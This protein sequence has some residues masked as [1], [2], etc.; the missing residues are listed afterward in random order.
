MNFARVLYND[1]LVWKK[2]LLSGLLD[3]VLIA[4]YWYVFQSW[5]WSSE[6]VWMWGWISVWSSQ[7]YTDVATARCRRVQQE[8][9]VG[10]F[11]PR[12]HGGFLP[13]Q[14]RFLFQTSLRWLIGGWRGA[15]GRRVIG[16][17]FGRHEFLHGKVWN[18]VKERPTSAS[19]WKAD[20]NIVIADLRRRKKKQEKKTPLN[21]R[22]REKRVNK[23][24][25]K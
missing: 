18:S 15:G 2:R 12:T 23:K 8:R 6:C 5:M 14:R 4:L 9:S 24:R 17:I 1:Y 3:W 19:M 13:H 22:K 10:V 25:R 21:V 20:I 7:E 16:Q 11:V